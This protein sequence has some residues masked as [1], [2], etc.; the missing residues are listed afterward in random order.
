MSWRTNVQARS[1]MFTIVTASGPCT[2]TRTRAVCGLCTRS[3]SHTATDDVIKQ[4]TQKQPPAFVFLLLA[5]YLRHEHLP[6]HLAPPTWRHRRPFA[7]PPLSDY[8]SDKHRTRRTT[9]AT[10]TTTFTTR[11]PHSL[12]FRPGPRQGN[13]CVR[14]WRLIKRRNSYLTIHFYSWFCGLPVAMNAETTRSEES[15][16][17]LVHVRLHRS[18]FT[19]YTQLVSDFSIEKTKWA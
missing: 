8:V 16:G 15:T 17:D 10:A 1:T 5:I 14:I 2:G 13:C 7:R 18:K 11:L 3:L 19:Q 4:Q 9:T 6:P 12:P